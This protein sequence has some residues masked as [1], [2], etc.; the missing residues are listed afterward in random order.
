MV[1]PVPVVAGRDPSSRTR[2]FEYLVPDLSHVVEN[3]A[4]AGHHLRV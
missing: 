4:H 3:A 1:V 2:D